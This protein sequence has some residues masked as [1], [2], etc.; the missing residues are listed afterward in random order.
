MDP[1]SVSCNNDVNFTQDGQDERAQEGFAATGRLTPLSET[2][3]YEF[4][5][6]AIADE[7]SPSAYYRLRSAEG[8]LN[9]YE[10]QRVTV[11]GTVVPGSEDY[12]FEG[13][14]PLVEVT[15][16]EPEYPTVGGIDP[17]TVFISG[18]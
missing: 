18:D 11:Y 16:V 2:A 3:P 15:R 1:D 4:G 9:G 7:V 8:L 14:P 5:T 13:G 10:S 12:M 6:H 17:Y